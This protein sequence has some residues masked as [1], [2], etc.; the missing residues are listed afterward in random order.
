MEKK[1]AEFRFIDMNVPIREQKQKQ[2]R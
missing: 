1:R 2:R